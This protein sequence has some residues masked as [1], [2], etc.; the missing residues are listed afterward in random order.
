MERSLHIKD[1]ALSLMYYPV[2]SHC[3]LHAKHRS[4][5]MTFNLEVSFGRFREVCRCCG[6]GE[7][8]PSAAIAQSIQNSPALR[9]QLSIV[10]LLNAASENTSDKSLPPA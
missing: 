1:V 4:V 5:R 2:K 10:K 9:T 8:M 3:N 7:D 6:V